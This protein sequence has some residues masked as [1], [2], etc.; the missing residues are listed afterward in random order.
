[1]ASYSATVPSSRPP[2]EVFA[3]LADFRSVAD[4]D[5]SISESVHINDDD[6]IKVGA[7]FRVTTETTIKDVVLEYTTIEL[8]RPHKIVLRGEND[9]MV[10]LDTI[11][12]RDD[13][14][15][16]AEVSYQAEIELKGA[17]KL[18]DPLLALGFRRLGDK[19]RD[20]LV[21]Q[22]KGDA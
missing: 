16:G 14:R 21:S 15:G 13:G 3:Y 18:A 4:W 19:A 8:D 2:D 11:T 6:P 10:S 9:S 22:L 7:I 20:G 12:V 5:P 1:M 17:R